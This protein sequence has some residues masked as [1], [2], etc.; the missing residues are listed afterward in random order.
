MPKLWKKTGNAKNNSDLV[1]VDSSPLVISRPTVVF[2]PGQMT[3]DNVQDIV[4]KDLNKVNSLFADMPQPPQVYLWS[5]PAHA[6]PANKS[7]LDTFKGVADY[8]TRHKLPPLDDNDLSAMQ[9]LLAYEASFQHSTTDLAREQAQ[10]L[11]MPLVTDKQGKPLPFDTARKNLRNL[12]FLA[13]CIG[14]LYVQELYNA[15]LV[16]MQF[17]GFR[18]DD[19]RKLLSEIVLVSFGSVA[20]PK[21]ERDRY[22]TISLIH[23][24]DSMLHK[25]DQWLHPL[26]SIFARFDRR[27][28]I[29]ELSESS[30]LVTATVMTSQIDRNKHN[31]VIAGVHLP[32]W[33]KDAFNHFMS[34]Y[35]NNDDNTSQVSRIVQYSL[36]NAVSRTGTVRPMSLMKAPPVAGKT[37]ETARYDRKIATAFQV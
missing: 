16:M 6:I 23:N 7:L 8:L 26:R 19:T 10:K 14:N 18:P 34:D 20:E 33:Q 30:L 25:K 15:A 36:I 24:D 2:F 28:K 3:R 13:Y 22:T 1:E 27:L 9:R 17:S 12:T 11:I 35:V 5:H 37:P 29:K 4:S 21:E 32:P 31:E